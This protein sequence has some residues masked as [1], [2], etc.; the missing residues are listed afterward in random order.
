MDAQSIALILQVASLYTLLAVSPG[1]NFIVIS[2]TAL[3]QSV[4]SALFVGAGVSTASLIWSAL[5]MA[6]WGAVVLAW[7][8]AM[9]VLQTLGAAYLIYLGLRLLFGARPSA[10][11]CPAEGVAAIHARS[12]IHWY[13]LG[14]ATNLTNPKTLVFFIS[15]FSVLFA[16][17]V[18][19][20]VGLVCL[21]VIGS[22][23]LAWNALVAVTFSRDALRKRYV[24]AK[25]YVDAVAGLCLA[26]F[27]IKLLVATLLFPSA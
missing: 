21:L 19:V 10:G 13:L 15:V 22:I 1:V 7:K 5:A 25:P 9:V 4:R 12:P 6:G 24:R 17:K 18:P 27:G 23:S 20:V 2:N 14:L 3:A 16:T 26:Y 8:P 11:E